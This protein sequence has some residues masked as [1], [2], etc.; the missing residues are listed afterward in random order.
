M[1]KLVK[2][3]AKHLKINQ[4]K[5]LESIIKDQIKD[6]DFKKIYI[7]MLCHG[8]SMI[9]INHNKV[10]LPTNKPE[11]KLINHAANELANILDKLCKENK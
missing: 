2:V 1:N 11:P 4:E 5:L 7:D 10:T 8:K 6:L 3:R 9:D